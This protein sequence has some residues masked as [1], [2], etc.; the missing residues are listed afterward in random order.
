VT[1]SR[2]LVR[3]VL[4]AA[5]VTAITLALVYRQQSDVS[6]LRS[7]LDQVGRFAPLAFVS[8]FALATIPFLTGAA[9]GLADDALFGPPWGALWNLVGATLGATLSFLAARY[10]AGDGVAR[11][12][13]GRHRAVV[14]GS[15]GGAG[16]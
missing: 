2:R 14:T 6:S 16:R 3:S 11:R 7:A 15:R 8:A 4:L 13:G 10:V 12:T 1:H 9:L 5:S